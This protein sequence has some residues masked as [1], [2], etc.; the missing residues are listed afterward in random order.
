MGSWRKGRHLNPDAPSPDLNLF[1]LILELPIVWSD[2]DGNAR[3][4]TNSRRRDPN[5]STVIF[6]FGEWAK[7]A[8]HA[9]ARKSFS[10]GAI[11]MLEGITKGPSKVLELKGCFESQSARRVG[12]TGLCQR[13]RVF[14]F[15]SDL[16]LSERF[17]LFQCI[18]A[19][20][21]RLSSS[22]WLFGELFRYG[23]RWK[24]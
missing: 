13:L 16:L 8:W 11:A 24:S 19:R 7:Q 20:M 21:L 12:P 14:D 10:D 15:F 17:L 9:F 4:F 5:F 22:Q 3:G 6:R 23:C 2:S 18:A 1:S